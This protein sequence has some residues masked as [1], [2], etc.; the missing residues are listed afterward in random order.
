MKRNIF[1]FIISFLLFIIIQNSSANNSQ[2]IVTLAPNLTEIVYALG[3]GNE[4]VGNTILCD[5]PEQ[6]KKVFKVG[7]FNNPSIERIVSSGANIVIA[8]EGNPIAK[9]NILKPM[10]IRVVQ[11]KPQSAQ[12]LPKIIKI[13]AIDLGVEK[14][15][16]ELANNIERSL[17]ELSEIKSSGKTFLL[18][19]QFNPIYS[20]SE[21]TWLGGLFKLSGLKNVVGNSVIKYPIVSSEFLVKNRPNIV[22]V[23]AVEGKN[24]TE[25]LKIQ[26]LKI[27]QIFG[28]DAEKIEVILVPKDVLVRP[29]PR[30]VEGIKFIES[31]KD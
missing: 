24:K 16:I 5:Y 9:L 26:K 2:K 17:K 6:A 14:K 12:D 19:L 4:L 22:L 1:Y 31:L 23:G 27:K 10:G 18:I 29:G 15:G 28:K 7:N 20:V 13:I 21:D 25:S 3:L 8:T 30:I 11:V